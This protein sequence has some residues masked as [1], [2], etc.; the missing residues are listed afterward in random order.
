M[1]D[2]QYLEHKAE[3]LEAVDTDLVQDTLEPI[4]VEQMDVALEAINALKSYSRYH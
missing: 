3:M 4:P 1:S 2:D